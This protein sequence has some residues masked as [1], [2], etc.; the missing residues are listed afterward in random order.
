MQQLVKIV[1]H[2][3]ADEPCDDIAI[4]LRLSLSR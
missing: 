3:V 4:P 2:G 1:A